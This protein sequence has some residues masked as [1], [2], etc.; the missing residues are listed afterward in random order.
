M[1]RA[2]RSREE[3]CCSEERRN[4]G[5]FHFHIFLSFFLV[6]LFTFNTASN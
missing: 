5:N 2:G 6:S 1:D 3:A 4:A